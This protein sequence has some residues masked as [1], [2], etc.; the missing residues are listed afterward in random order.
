[1]LVT[2]GLSKTSPNVALLVNWPSKNDLS[3]NRDIIKGRSVGRISLTEAKPW[4][5]EQ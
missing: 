5:M 1:M 4:K 2:A 3:F